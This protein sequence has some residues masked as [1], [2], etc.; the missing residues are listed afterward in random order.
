[1]TGP[2]S[3]ASLKKLVRYD[4]IL[5]PITAFVRQANVIDQTP[6]QQFDIPPV[7]PDICIFQ[8]LP[9]GPYEIRSP[10]AYPFVPNDLRRIGD[11]LRDRI[12]GLYDVAL[13]H[14]QGEIGP[15]IVL[16]T[17]NLDVKPA[18]RRL[19]DMLHSTVDLGMGRASAE[20]L[21]HLH[22]LVDVFESRDGPRAGST[23][24]P[25]TVL[26][27]DLCLRKRFG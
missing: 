17:A 12:T 25:P 9:E 11:T 4:V 20:L 8:R 2:R 27:G 15:N 19:V 1:M 16:L 26:R 18:L 23:R 14:F 13:L 10:L 7:S 22:K 24:D 21:R 6:G 3:P 5:A